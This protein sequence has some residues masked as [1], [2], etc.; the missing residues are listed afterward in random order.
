VKDRLL[1]PWADSTDGTHM[2][3]D[4]GSWRKVQERDRAWERINAAMGEIDPGGEAAAALTHALVRLNRLVTPEEHMVLWET[5]GDALTEI[6]D[7][8]R[9]DA[10]RHAGWRGLVER[11]TH[12]DGE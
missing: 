6:A 11:H 2:A 8:R 7:S 12:H 1:K 3:G 10:S 9:R 4:P 5:L